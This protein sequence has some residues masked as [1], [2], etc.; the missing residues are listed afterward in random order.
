MPCAPLLRPCR[1]SSAELVSP[2][3]EGGDFCWRFDTGCF[4][5][6]AYDVARAAVY[7]YDL[8]DVEAFAVNEHTVVCNCYVVGSANGRFTPASRYYCSVACQAAA[9]RENSYRY[10]HAMHIGWRSFFTNQ[11]YVL[12]GKYCVI[13]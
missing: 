7:R 10:L 12:G 9:S 1:A 6:T 11:N 4:D 5:V 13:R 2:F 3:Q 8:T